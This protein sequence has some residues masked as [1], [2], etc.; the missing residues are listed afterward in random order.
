MASTKTLN[1]WM[2][3]CRGGIDAS[4][5][6]AS[7]VRIHGRVSNP[8]AANSFEGVSIFASFKTDPAL[9][10]PGRFLESRSDLEQVVSSFGAF[11]ELMTLRLEL[12]QGAGVGESLG[13]T[14]RPLRNQSGAGQVV[15][16]SESD[17]R[18]WMAICRRISKD[19]M[20]AG[21]GPSRVDGAPSRQDIGNLA[22]ESRSSRLS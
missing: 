16:A 7:P 11:C 9:G 3:L 19:E 2:A 17:L 4:A 15:S 5:V 10:H 21:V 6:A 18:D 22:K 1:A 8:D 13:E 14:T 20:S 12:D